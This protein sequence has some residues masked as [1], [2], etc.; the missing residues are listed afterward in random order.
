MSRAKILIHPNPIL[1]QKSQP[2][3]NV[4]ASEIQT[5]IGQM[6]EVL[7]AEEGL[8]LAAPQVGEN[9]RLI[10]INT[11]DGIKPLI[12]P[13]IRR[14]SLGKELGEEGCLSIPGVYGL[15][16]RLRKI[17]VLAL[18]QSGKK[19]KFIANGMLARVIQHEVDHL[20]GILFIDKVKRVTQGKEKLKF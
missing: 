7:K 13:V 10:L 15:V 3:E 19:I 6:T 16:N 12:N 14:R 4:L 18:D 2:I 5:L 1:R 17:K 8:G 20:N 9:L 11:K